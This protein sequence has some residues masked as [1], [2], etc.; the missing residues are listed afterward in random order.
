MFYLWKPTLQIWVGLLFKASLVPACC[1]WKHL[2]MVTRSTTRDNKTSCPRVD[3]ACVEGG[4]PEFHI[5]HSVRTLR[6][7]QSVYFLE[8][9]FI[10]LFENVTLSN[11]CYFWRPSNFVLVRK[12]LAEVKRLLARRRGWYVSFQS[13]SLEWYWDSLHA[14][15]EGCNLQSA[16]GRCSVVTNATRAQ[17]QSKYPSSRLQLSSAIGRRKGWQLVVSS[18]PLGFQDTLLP[19]FI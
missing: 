2:P 7:V 13:W 11:R 17:Q 18:D 9:Q 14:E 12:A 10:M 5:V 8:V 3:S 1:R 16:S 6:E 15:A 4:S 19:I